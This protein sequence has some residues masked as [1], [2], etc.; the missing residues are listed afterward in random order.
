[1]RG[2]LTDEAIE[3]A[4]QVYLTMTP[5]CPECEARSKMLLRHCATCKRD[6]GDTVA[7]ILTAVA[8]QILRDAADAVD[9]DPDYPMGS[10]AQTAA[11]EWLRTHA[12]TEEQS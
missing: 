8:P 9:N 6:A 1:M 10:M 3:L 7:Y 2:P 11:A 4:T 12:A 5:F